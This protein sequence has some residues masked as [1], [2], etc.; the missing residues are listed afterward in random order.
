MGQFQT[1]QNTADNIEEETQTQSF[2]EEQTFVPRPPIIS[3]RRIQIAKKSIFVGD[4]IT[5]LSN[6]VLSAGTVKAI[7]KGRVEIIVW[8]KVNGQ[9]Y[10]NPSKIEEV[11]R[12]YGF[13]LKIHKE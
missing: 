7:K 6:G 10:L 2:L 3:N 1:R 4:L 9:Y 11:R 13:W 5:Y 8:E 12:D